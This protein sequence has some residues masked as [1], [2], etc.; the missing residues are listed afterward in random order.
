VDDAANLHSK[1]IRVSGR[2]ARGSLIVS[3]GRR[4]ASFDLAGARHELHARCRCAVPDNLAEGIDV[5][6]EGTLLRDGFHG[7]KVITQCASKYERSE[8]VAAHEDAP[9]KTARR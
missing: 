7:H 3:E 2:V 8:S 9:P 1:R 5:V 4:Q 6:I